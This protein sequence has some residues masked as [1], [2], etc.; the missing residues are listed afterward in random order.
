MKMD[1]NDGLAPAVESILAAA[2]DRGGD[3]GRVSV[4]AR[5]LSAAV[6]RA[7][8]AGRA[9]VIAEVK[10]TSPTTEGTREE[11]PVALARGM[12][13][14]G[15]AA[16]SVLTEPEHFGGSPDLPEDLR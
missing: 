1:R 15:A 9:P 5:S 2:R 11:D 6:E 16:L 10:P 3:D 14:G 7:E 12:A 4:D 8:S 13:E